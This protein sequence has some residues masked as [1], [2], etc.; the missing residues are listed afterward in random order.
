MKGEKDPRAPRKPALASGTVEIKVPPK[1][2]QL[3]LEV[4][5]EDPAVEP[6]GETV[7]SVKVC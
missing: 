1:N 3:L 2:K 4:T 7:V 5:P 6:G